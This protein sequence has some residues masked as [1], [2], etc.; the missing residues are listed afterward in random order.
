MDG[1]CAG[2]PGEGAR[3]AGSLSGRE[4][5]EGA[6]AGALLGSFRLSGPTRLGARPPWLVTGR[7]PTVGRLWLTMRVDWANGAAR[8]VLLRSGREWRG[9]LLAVDRGSF[10][11]CVASHIS[12]T[13]GEGRRL[14]PEPRPSGRPVFD[15]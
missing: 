4:E 15:G 12:L 9:S 3:I 6:G 8:A 11:S 13:L 2:A 1:R 14:N 5:G 10:S 7:G